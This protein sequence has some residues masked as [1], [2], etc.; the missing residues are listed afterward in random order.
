[1][2]SIY[3]FPR[4]CQRHKVFLGWAF[5]PSLLRKARIRSATVVAHTDVPS[6]FPPSGKLRQRPLKSSVERCLETWIQFHEDFVRCRRC[7]RLLGSEM[8]CA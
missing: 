8:G 1:M 7:R 4:D 6:T 2:V 5:E 3:N